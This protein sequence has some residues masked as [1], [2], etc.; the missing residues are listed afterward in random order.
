MFFFKN[1]GIESEVCKVAH[2]GKKEPLAES[3]KFVGCMSQSTFIPQL[4]LF[5][6]LVNPH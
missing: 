2:A 1:K 3:W 4:L 5:L 6:E